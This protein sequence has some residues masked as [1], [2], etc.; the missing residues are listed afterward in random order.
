VTIPIDQESKEDNNLVLQQ[1]VKLDFKNTPAEAAPQHYS[2]QIN[3][4]H[5]G[6][7]FTKY[8]DRILFS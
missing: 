8:G 1:Q 7:Y 2:P 3:N 4:H 6:T 5:Q